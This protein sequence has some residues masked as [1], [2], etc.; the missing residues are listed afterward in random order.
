V[1]NGG[2]SPGHVVGAVGSVLRAVVVNRFVR[3][4]LRLIPHEQK[5][6]QRLTLT[7]LIETGEL[8][9]V[10][11]RTYPLADTAEGLR[12]VEQR[13]ARGAVVIT[14]ARGRPGRLLT[15]ESALDLLTARER[16][17]QRLAERDALIRTSA[18]LS[19]APPCSRP[20]TCTRSPSQRFAG[21]T[22]SSAGGATAPSRG[23]LG[24]CTRPP[25]ESENGGGVGVCHSARKL[26]TS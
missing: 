8:T 15:P 7:G 23:A 24:K 1:L 16:L 26:A 18:S 17:V 19:G 12:H 22:A 13:H 2:G 9:P 6:E 5:Q 25:P 10:L 14:V 21:W 20:S 3:E 4:R 11:D